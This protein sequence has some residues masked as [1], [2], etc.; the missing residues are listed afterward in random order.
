MNLMETAVYRANH[1]TPSGLKSLETEDINHG[2]SS[3][4][5]YPASCTCTS[6][7]GGTRLTQQRAA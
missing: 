6:H 4:A 7:K 5:A 3:N 1:T 2:D